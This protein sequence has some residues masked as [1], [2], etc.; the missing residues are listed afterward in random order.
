V[1]VDRAGGGFGGG[2]TGG[3]HKGKECESRS[4]VAGRKV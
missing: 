2:N 3:G 4:E 1:G